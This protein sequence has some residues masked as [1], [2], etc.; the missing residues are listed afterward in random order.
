MSNRSAEICN[1]RRFQITKWKIFTRLTA[2]P[3]DG[4]KGR[5]KSDDLV[6]R[7]SP[8]HKKMY[9]REPDTTLKMR[10]QEERGISCQHEI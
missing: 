3:A 1:H 5:L 2:I 6:L 8:F 9:M 10:Y 4:R 7:Q